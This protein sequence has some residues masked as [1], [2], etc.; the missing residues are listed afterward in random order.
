MNCHLRGTEVQLH[1]PG[2]IWTSLFRQQKKSAQGKG[3]GGCMGGGMGMG[4][5]GGCMGGGM[6]MGGMGGM[7]KGMGCKGG[8]GKGDSWMQ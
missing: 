4:G 5:M 1:N 6:G 2:S 8:M 7:G 3:M